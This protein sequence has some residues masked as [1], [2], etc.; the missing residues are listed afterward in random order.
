MLLKPKQYYLCDN[1]DYTK[2]FGV[3]AQDVEIDFPELIYTDS[4]YIAN[5]T[6]Y[7]IY[8]NFIITFDITLNN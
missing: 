2:K 5:I 4:E 6:S 8:D 3:I 1:K 7:A